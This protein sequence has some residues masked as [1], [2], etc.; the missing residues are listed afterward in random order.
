MSRSERYNAR[1]LTYSAAHRAALPALYGR[2]GHRADACDR[3]WTEY[4]HFC[5]VPLL[6]GEEVR[7]RGQNLAD[8]S[9]RVTG[10]L[11]QMAGL[12]AWLIA[13][14]TDRPP[15]VQ[16]QMDRLAAQLRRLEAAWPITGF[17]DRVLCPRPGPFQDFT[18]RQHW[19]R[20]ALLH[21]SHEAACPAVPT[22]ERRRAR[23]G[24]T[25]LYAPGLL[26]IS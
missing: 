18:P 23:A 9:W 21:A 4:C 6:I 5:Q 13:W 17:T 14:R 20:I 3:D 25:R 8:K 26:E 22:L 7:D 2:I 1:D 15:D 11:A 16:A 10:R 12:P 19:R 24:L